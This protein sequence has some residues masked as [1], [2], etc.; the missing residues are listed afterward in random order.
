MRGVLTLISFIA[1]FFVATFHCHESLHNYL[2][3]TDRMNIIRGEWTFDSQDCVWENIVSEPNAHVWFG[4]ANGTVPDAQFNN[5][6][7]FTLI[8]VM[9]V[10]NSSS[11][12]F[13]NGGLYFHA[14]KTMYDNDAGEDYYFGIRIGA[15]KSNIFLG[16]NNNGTY[17]K[18]YL[19]P[20]PIAF[21][22][23]TAYQ[24]KVIANH[25]RYTF[26]INDTLIWEDEILTQFQHG[27]FAIRS[28]WMPSKY[29]GLYVSSDQLTAMPTWNP[30][31]FPSGMPSGTPTT[32]TSTLP[33]SETNVSN[34]VPNETS[35]VMPVMLPTLIPTASQHTR[36]NNG[37]GLDINEMTLNISIICAT[38]GIIIIAVTMIICI[39]K[40]CI[41]RLKYK[42]LNNQLKKN[43]NHVYNDCN[44]YGAIGDSLK[45]NK[46]T[47][48]N[49]N[50]KLS[51]DLLKRN[52]N[53]SFGKIENKHNLLI[54][55]DEM[56]SDDSD[57]ESMYN[58]DNKRDI[59]MEGATC[60]E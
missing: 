41:K 9:S 57:L 3:D 10:P 36:K 58:N 17:H 49:N 50:A 16:K 33:I 52:R 22:F 8:V 60:K 37:N 6:S 35:N 34:I 32:M 59:S 15:Q 55:N 1:G 26:Y 14:E 45:C 54:D 38:A 4:N 30:S 2:C 11:S 42:T 13:F 31:M 25:T 28:Y 24:L 46:K 39:Y 47:N 7:V 51:C 19:Q 56:D 44:D 40:L 12:I 23:N 53:K 43:E 21:E 48:S 29:Y 27:S 18:I 20:S 5:L